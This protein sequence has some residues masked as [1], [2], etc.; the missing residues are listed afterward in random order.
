MT[1]TIAEL[2]ALLREA[3]STDDVIHVFS[4]DVEVLT[5]GPDGRVSCNNFQGPA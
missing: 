3:L 2:V 4:D 1:L 5:V